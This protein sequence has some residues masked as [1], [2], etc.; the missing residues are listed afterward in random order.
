MLTSRGLEVYTRPD[1]RI[2]PR[3]QTA[4]DVVAILRSYL[5]EVGVDVRLKTPVRGIES[6]RV[7]LA[8]G[9]SVEAGAIV[10]A[11]GGCSYPASGTSGD[12]WVWLRRLGHT[13][14][15]IRA[16]LAPIHLTCPLEALAGVALRDVVLKGRQGKRSCRWRGDLLFTH[17]G[18][19]G[20]TTLGI[21]REVAEMIEVGPVSL[22]VDFYPDFP[23]ESMHQM[24]REFAAK[25]PRRRVFAMLEERV[26]EA[27]AKVLG[28]AFGDDP[29]GAA[30]SAKQRN[31]LVEQVK[32]WSLGEVAAVDLEKGEV[33][34]GGVALDEVDPQ[35]MESLLVPGLF[36]CGEVLDIA[37]PVGGYNLQAAFATGFV[38]GE[39]AARKVS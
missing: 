33:A 22:E 24:F 29:M 35:T 10:V 23:F 30:F 5:D 26:P 28:E 31:R 7:L 17:R 1:G 12:A 25:H 36:L 8:G 39:C 19:S 34:A 6:G 18:V 37:G 21:S 11:A 3:H 20:P 9:E 27:V 38:A 14:V 2:F 15:P 16:A 13:I 4:K 32:G